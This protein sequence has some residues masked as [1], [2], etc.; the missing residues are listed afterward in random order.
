MGSC[1]APSGLARSAL[2]R[3]GALALGW[4]G[5]V[6]F[7][8]GGCA[9]RATSAECAQ[10]LER[11]VELLVREHN[12]GLD[13]EAMREQTETVRARAREI[14]SFAECP[15]QIDVDAVRCVMTAPNVDEL[16]KCL[17]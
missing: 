11:Y 3:P 2:R 4:V 1:A 9:R 12:P 15:R 7:A 13:P 6:L 5:M 14:P 10:V 8:N 17:E 16:E